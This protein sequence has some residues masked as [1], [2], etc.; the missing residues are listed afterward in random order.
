MPEALEASAEGEIRHR[1]SKVL[2]WVRVVLT[3][4]ERCSL[5]ADIFAVSLLC[6]YISCYSLLNSS[7]MKEKKFVLYS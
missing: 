6:C 4:S 7:C 1:L 5:Y 2:V 3:F